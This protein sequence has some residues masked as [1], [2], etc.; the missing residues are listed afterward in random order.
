MTYLINKIQEEITD[1]KSMLDTIK[2]FHDE[3]ICDFEQTKTEIAIMTRNASNIPSVYDI[4]GSYHL[5]YTKASL[6]FHILKLKSLHSLNEEIIKIVK[7][8]KLNLDLSEKFL[9]D[10]NVDEE[11]KESNKH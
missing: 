1:Y 8:V 5:P 4:F 9:K 3:I 10:L 2:E 6:M 7:I 11:Q